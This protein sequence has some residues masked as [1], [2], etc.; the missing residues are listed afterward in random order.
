[1]LELYK[2][3]NVDKEH[4]LIGLFREINQKFNPKKV[5]Y[6]GCYVHI[7][8]SLIFSDVTYVDSFKDTNKFFDNEEV[9]AFV[10]KKKEY[11]EKAKIK[12]IHQDYTK[13]LPLDKESFDL[14]LSFF[15]GFV[16]QATKKYLKKGG[17][18][19]CND[20]HGDASMASIDYDYELIAV[21]SRI[22]DDNYA[23]LDENLG[24]YLI[25]KKKID[26][27]ELEKKMKGVIFTKSASG[28]IFR[29]K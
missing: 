7:T 25:P 21:Y 2:K 15:G 27:N 11:E 3:F 17:I 16:G 23:I 20:S 8:P 19:V 26:K 28:Y 18:L 24:G 5:I 22:S 12:F 1:M 29:K 6:P 10:N 4:T 9:I 13:E 14:I